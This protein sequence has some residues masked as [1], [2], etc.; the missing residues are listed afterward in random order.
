MQQ[1]MTTSEVADLIGVAKWRIRRLYETGALPEPTRFGARRMIHG[2]DIPAIVDALRERG[3][4]PEPTDGGTIY[5][6]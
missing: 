3:W 2:A 6:S 4:L 5:D 1:M